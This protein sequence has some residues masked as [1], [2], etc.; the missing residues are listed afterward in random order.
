MTKRTKQEWKKLYPLF[1]DKIRKG[2]SPTI[3]I[4]ENLVD[5]P[6]DLLNK[7]M[8]VNNLEEETDV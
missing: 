6:D 2:Q 1:V 4:T 5:I 3:I 8:I 7:C